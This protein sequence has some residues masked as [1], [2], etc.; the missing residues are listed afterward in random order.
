MSQHVVSI[1]IRLSLSGKPLAPRASI[2]VSQIS[3]P[4]PSSSFNFNDIRSLENYACVV[5]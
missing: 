2:K 1:I 4:Q 5:K 3:S